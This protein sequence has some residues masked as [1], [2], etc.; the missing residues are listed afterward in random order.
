MLTKRMWI[1]TGLYA[2]IIALPLL[3]AAYFALYQNLNIR[4]EI[5]VNRNE[6]F[7]RVTADYIGY[8]LTDVTNSASYLAQAAAEGVSP[9]TLESLLDAAVRSFSSVVTNAFITD[10]KG[11]VKYSWADDALGFDVS[12][13]KY[14]T[15]TVEQRKLTITTGLTGLI[16][17][18]PMFVVSAPIIRN[19]QLNGIVAITVG[20]AEV[21]AGLERAASGN[22]SRVIVFEP[23]GEVMCGVSG[24]SREAFS[25]FVRS[26]SSSDS[27]STHE[28]TYPADGQPSLISVVPVPET[29][30][31]LM[32]IQP[33]A[34]LRYSHRQLFTRNSWLL[35]VAGLI[36]YSIFA[37]LKSM[38]R[39]EHEAR[40][41]RA[42]QLAMVGELAAGIA[43]EIRNPLTVVKGFVQFR[44][45]DQPLGEDNYSLILSEVE[46]IEA[47]I[48]EFLLFSKPR[49]LETKVC[50][51]EEIV[52]DT[53][54]MTKSHA[55]MHNVDIVDI[56]APYLPSVEVDPSLLKQVF[57]NLIKNAIEAMPDGGV[58][59]VTVYVRAQKMMIEFK[60]DGV[61]MNQEVLRNIGTPFFSTKETGTG[62]GVA[63]SLIIMRR[64][65]GN[66][67]YE[68][69]PGKGTTATVIL[70]L[71][72][73]Y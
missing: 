11:T 66:I 58:L 7:A 14:F 24:L 64:L 30:W 37:N 68:S 9:N 19:G 71:S 53:V 55:I 57:V 5:L 15:T 61:G 34:G 12:E 73:E 49:T 1:K 4:Y 56:Y 31:K 3:I 8:V 32:F 13:R 21:S 43:H 40:Y 25:E 72:G 39:E 50:R 42:E 38:E 27:V 65:G 44:G 33:L 29:S 54:L 47:L 17:G 70:P 69:I 59:T 35:L 41:R 28:Y 10:H 45:P 46:R 20:L 63:N 52:K 48:N 18:K 6:F 51:V 23:S 62:M 67:E 22:G 36:I 60:D 16:S 2:C 26:F